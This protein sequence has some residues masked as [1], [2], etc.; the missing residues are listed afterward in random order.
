MQVCMHIFQSLNSKTLREMVVH[1]RGNI[2]H[3]FMGTNTD[4]Y[5]PASDFLSP[6]EKE[7]PD[8]R[9]ALSVTENKGFSIA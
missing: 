1:N 8:M 2:V 9:G 4:N 6:L 7:E 3:F 5:T